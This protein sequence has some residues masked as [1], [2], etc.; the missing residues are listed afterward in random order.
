MSEPTP[1]DRMRGG[2]DAAPAADV[3]RRAQATSFRPDPGMEVLVALKASD[4]DRF[5]RVVSS[6]QKIS[7][8]YYLAAKAEAADDHG[9]AA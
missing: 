7:V 6:S 2:F 9:T 4:P 5:A 8:G 3:I 1:R